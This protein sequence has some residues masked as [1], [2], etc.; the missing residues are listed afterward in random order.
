MNTYNLKAIIEKINS[1]F[2]KGNFAFTAFKSLEDGEEYETWLVEGCN[3]RYVLKKAKNYEIEIYNE[4]FFEATKG[5]P[6]YLGS[7]TYG[8]ESYF[9]MDF[10]SGKSMLHCD[11]QSLIKTLDA[12]ISLQNKYW[13]DNQKF[14]V[15]L[16]LE[17]SLKSRRERMNY[18]NDPAIERFC[19][20]Y[21]SLY[22]QLPKTLCHDDMLPFNV[23]I[24]D[25]F[26]T[27]IDWEYAGMLP[28]PTP[29][30]RLLAHCENNKDAFFYI[31]EEDKK[32]AIEYY[33]SKFVFEKGISYEEY[34]RTI[35][36]FFLYEY[37]EW[38]MLGNKYEDSDKE[39]C[40]K[41]YLKAR[42]LISSIV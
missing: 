25:S 15:G 2:S 39:R 21:L 37:T 36:L 17:K 6:R 28:Y 27:I 5:A 19:S 1:A 33:Y 13:Q 41:Y 20:E 40:D 10:A 26:A 23:I 30:V 14:A 34:I 24:G 16:T 12:L 29:L 3:Q 31:T 7:T 35:R 42:E 11:R 38:I 32:F 4:F 9:L 8:E 18:L 22:V